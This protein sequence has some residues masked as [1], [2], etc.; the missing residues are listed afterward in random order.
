MARAGT[1]HKGGR[2]KGS[3]WLLESNNSSNNTALLS[4]QVWITMVDITL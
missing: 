1:N 4:H 2:P 3:V